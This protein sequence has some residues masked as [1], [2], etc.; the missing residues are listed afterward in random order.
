MRN[1][2]FNALFLLALV[3]RM[4]G[5]F[6]FAPVSNNNSN[7]IV[8]RV[9]TTS[10]FEDHWGR[11]LDYHQEPSAERTLYEFLNA[12]Q[13]A[14]RSELRQ[15]YIQLAK[16]SHPDAQI[17]GATYSSAPDFGEVAKAWSV[18]GDAKTRKRYDREL[19]AKELSARAEDFI[20][21]A[22]PA[23]AKALDDIAIPF[24][25]QTVVTTWAVGNAV[26]SVAK[27]VVKRSP[28]KLVAGSD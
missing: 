18:L 23:V 6:A 24:L 17:S 7:K 9:A 11:P 28:A 20:D 22:G 8:R 15:Q 14:T 4:Q 16:L 19:R 3:T 12:P 27:S 21:R 1:Y 10:F 13:T 2:F 25:R 5:N 26:A